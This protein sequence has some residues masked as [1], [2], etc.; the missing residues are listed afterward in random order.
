MRTI[1][2]IDKDIR[3]NHKQMRRLEKIDLYSAASWQDAW[4]KHPDLR[5]REDALYLERG[6]A[7]QARDE[8][9]HKLAMQQARKA[10]HMVKK[11]KH[12]KCPT[13]GSM[14]LAA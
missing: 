6:I 13:C 7:Q 4:D 8:A 5:A 14:V 12:K 10:R 2:Q 9:A 1:A 11:I 3:A